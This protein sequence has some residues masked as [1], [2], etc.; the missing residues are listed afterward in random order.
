M[1]STRSERER[2]D[3]GLRKIDVSGRKLC[4]E[5]RTDPL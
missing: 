5:G 3:L 1:S 4:H 2:G